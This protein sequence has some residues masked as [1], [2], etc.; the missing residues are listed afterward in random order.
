MMLRSRFSELDFGFGV[1]VNFDSLCCVVFESDA[2]MTVLVFSHLSWLVNVR[3]L[4]IGVLVLKDL[5]KGHLFRIFL[6][7]ELEASYI[8]WV[9]YF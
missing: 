5:L 2:L 6:W 1:L 3:F 9:S 7:S 4:F 8:L